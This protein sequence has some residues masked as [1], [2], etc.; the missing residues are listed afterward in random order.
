MHLDLYRR[1]DQKGPR[2]TLLF[3]HGGGWV[4]GNKRQQGLPMLHHLA[5]QGWL[6]AS[7]NY[8][9]SPKA[10]FPDMLID[11]AHA[12]AWL[13][14]EGL[15]Y[16]ADDARMVLAGGSAGG[17]LASLLALS[18]EDPQLQ[19]AVSGQDLQVKACVGLYGVYDLTDSEETHSNPGLMGLWV[20]RVLKKRFTEFPEAFQK[21]SPLHQIHSKTPA[22]L[23]VQGK[24]DTMAP[25]AGARL[26]AK[27][28]KKTSQEPVVLMEFSGT[29][30]A[31]DILPSL[32]TRQMI[33]GVGRFLNLIV[34]DLPEKKI[35]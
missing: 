19:K 29:Q 2:P 10:T 8:R 15:K 35:N 26:F 9:L 30:H 14:T 17:H 7:A 12:L 33:R 11:L 16:G 20:R 32:R 18:A 5:D 27:A 21:A 4:L 23:L 13:K 34:K 6:C 24:N 31:F 28:L 25:L 22:M 1:R 3:A